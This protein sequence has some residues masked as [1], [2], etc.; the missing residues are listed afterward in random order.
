[1]SETKTTKTTTSELAVQ[2]EQIA[3]VMRKK[4]FI[5]YEK[6]ARDSATELRRLEC[7]NT[8]WREAINSHDEYVEGLKARIAKLEEQLRATEL[9]L[10]PFEDLSRKCGWSEIQSR[11][12][13][14]YVL[15]EI[16]GRDQY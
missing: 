11:P 8:T 2:L 10:K 16:E 15:D 13:Y 6:D 1:M 9:H 14:L 5:G 12:S 7:E 4:G 3:N